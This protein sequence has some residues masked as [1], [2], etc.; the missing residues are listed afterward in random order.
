MPRSS[1]Q[2]MNCGSIKQNYYMTL[3]KLE[4]YPDGEHICISYIICIYIY[5]LNIFIFYFLHCTE[6]G[7]GFHKIQTKSGWRISLRVKIKSFYSKHSGK[8]P[9]TIRFSTPFAQN[10]T[11][12]IWK[13]KFE[14]HI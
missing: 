6:S 1:T 10:I 4:A 11:I 14:K 9:C 5:I 8:L 2:Q 3:L 12:S 13:S 7:P